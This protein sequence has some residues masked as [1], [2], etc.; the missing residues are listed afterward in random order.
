MVKM[1]V[2]MKANCLHVVTLNRW[3]N[4]NYKSVIIVYDYRTD[5]AT[6]DLEL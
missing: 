6:D 1:T 4:L 5:N 3:D 2:Q